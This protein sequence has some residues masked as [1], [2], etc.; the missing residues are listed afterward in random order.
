MKKYAEDLC[1]EYDFNN[2]HEFYDYIIE[3]LVNGHRQQVRNLFNELKP[4]SQEEFLINYL[5]IS[6]GYQK[7]VLNICIGELC[8]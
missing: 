6:E 2:K 3:S 5:D 8:K 4:G 7:S 1:K